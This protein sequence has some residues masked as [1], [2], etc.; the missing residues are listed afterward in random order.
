M[1][2]FDKCVIYFEDFQKG[3]FQLLSFWTHSWYF[4]KL[5]I[6]FHFEN[7]DFIKIDPEQKGTIGFDIWSGD[8]GIWKI[9][10]IIS[11][12]RNQ[13]FRKVENKCWNHYEISFLIEWE[14]VQILI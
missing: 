7:I 8:E 13:T 9:L 14:T 1:D 11:T 10:D 5:F 4:L 12:F 6:I 2:K 3:L